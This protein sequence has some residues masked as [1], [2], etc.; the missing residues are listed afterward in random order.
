MAVLLSCSVV[1][2]VGAVVV[3]IAGVIVTSG[4]YGSRMAWLL[5]VVLPLLLLTALFARLACRPAGPNGK[6]VATSSRLRPMSAVM[7]LVIGF[8]FVVLTFLAAFT[9]YGEVAGVVGLVCIVSGAVLL[10]RSSAPSR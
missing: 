5:G 2:F 7:L 6:K 1:S 4:T 9:I 8:L 3:F 10:G